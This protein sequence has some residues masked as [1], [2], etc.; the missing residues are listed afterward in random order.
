MP[1][2]AAQMLAGSGGGPSRDRSFDFNVFASELFKSL[3]VH[4][5]ARAAD[6]GSLGAVVVR[7]P[8]IRWVANRHHRAAVGLGLV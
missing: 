1:A 2:Q 8:G 4:K 5:T 6:E 3:I 7:T